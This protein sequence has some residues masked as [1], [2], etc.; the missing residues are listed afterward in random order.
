M[1]P[2]RWMRC[3]ESFRGTEKVCS[4]LPAQFEFPEQ[5]EA[6]YDRKQAQLI[7]CLLYWTR[8][9][10]TCVLGLGRIGALSI[11]QSHVRAVRLDIRKTLG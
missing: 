3:T 9:K 8:G 2:W 10:R 6:G 11:G 7:R 4:A 5:E 1:K